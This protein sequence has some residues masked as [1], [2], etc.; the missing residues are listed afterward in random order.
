MA[1]NKKINENLLNEVAEYFES[2][3]KYE[4]ITIKIETTTV[5]EK[6]NESV[7]TEEQTAYILVESDSIM[8][9][10]KYNYEEK[11]IENGNT[12]TT[13]KVFVSEELIG[14]KYERL[15][16]YLKEKLHIRKSDLETNIEIVIQ[17]ANRIL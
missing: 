17:A 9:H 8:G 16:E 13:G 6:G 15:R 12:K 2:T 10:Y 14:E 7:S 11:T 5:D 3:F 1:N 4:Q